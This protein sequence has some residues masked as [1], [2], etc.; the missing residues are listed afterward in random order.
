[1]GNDPTPLGTNQ[2]P[3]QGAPIGDSPVQNPGPPPDSHARL[4]SM[5]QGLGVGL[6]AFG[7]AIATQGR[8]G[9][10]EEVQNYQLK[11]QQE[12][13]EEQKTQQELSESQQRIL[14]NRALTNHMVL[15]DQINLQ[16]APDEIS[17][18]HLANQKAL[19]DLY[20]EAGLSPMAA[21]LM[22][23][24]QP[25]DAHMNAVSQAANGDL[26]NNT[27]IPIH[28]NGPG[29]G[30]TTNIFS[31]DSMSHLTFSKDKIAP[32]L[33]QESNMLGVAQARLGAD[34]PSVKQ[35]KIML[36]QAQQAPQMNG[37][38][39]FRHNVAFQNV[40][41]NAVARQEAMLETQK[42]IADTSKAQSEAVKSGAEAGVAQPMEAA[43]LT[44]QQAKAATAGP[45]ARAQLS[46][47]Q[48]GATLK[49]ET[50]KEMRELASQPDV[51]GNQAQLGPGG[52]KEYTQKYN[53]FTKNQ[54]LPLQ[55]VEQQFAQFNEIKND[56]DQGK[57]MTGA[58]SVVG[59][60]NAIGISAAPLKGA[61]FRITGNTI[62]EHK[63]ARGLGESLY[64]KLLSLKNG[65][66]I[67]PQQMRDY[68]DLA[69]NA[70]RNQYYQAIDEATREGLKVDF[71]PK[72]QQPNQPIDMGTAQIY[73]HAANGD[74]DKARKAAS[75]NGW[76][77]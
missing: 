38:D 1:M 40:L 59:L 71:V 32:V 13:R 26:V 2:P 44:E 70:R 16:K 53:N 21:V 46:E 54:V 7:K 72:P 75:S 42:K 68:A 63:D 61:G 22:I 73:L 49:N 24:N 3:P 55:K 69:A 67:T 17:S 14:Y 33:A 60:F 10:V 18:A 39:F 56:I 64:Q 34:D 20:K 4:F 5:I 51:F 31:S 76:A 9:G 74:K 15:Q 11:Q 43:K 27:A 62:D 35:A 19:L 6:G 58:Q 77:F 23:Q 65:D 29:K 8:E 41:S 12:A 30:G 25:P 66:I 50:V 48:A 36:E 37:E 47:A 28:D 57:S 45:L 52:V